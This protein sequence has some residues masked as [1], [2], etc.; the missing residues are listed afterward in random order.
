VP[1]HDEEAV[2]AASLSKLKDAASGRAEILLVADN[3]AD[4]TADI[5]RRLGVEV[6]ERADAVRK[7]KGFALDFARSKLRLDPPE[8]VVVIDADCFVEP[9]SIERLVAEC[10]ATAL[11]CQAIYLQT[12]VRDGPPPLQL[13]TFAF[14]VRNAVRQ[15]GLE[16]LGRGTHLVGT[17]MAFPWALFDRAALATD[18]IVEDLALGLEFIDAGYPPLLVDDAVVW[19]HPAA[20]HSTLDQ[21]R[22]W[23]G[24]YL[25]TAFRWA[26]WMIASS[27][28]R[29]DPRGLWSGA[30]LLIPPFALLL[31]MDV[32][33]LCLAILMAW[34]IGA[35]QWPAAILGGSIAG[36]G[37]ALVLAWFAGGSRFVSLRGLARAPLYL[38]WKLPLYLGLVRR[39]APKEWVRT[40]RGESS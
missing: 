29:G 16:R 11:P 14:F 7:G 19:S 26:P 4:S 15:R 24:G 27:L 40:H 36:T 1:A 10:A 22:R 2:L 35:G 34:Q 38:I 17:G 30:S 39:G 13:S 21:R 18:N 37:I 8:V 28:R 25:A 3:C 20:Q 5:A 33:A 32:G 9:E 12:P 6:I 23:E 31:L